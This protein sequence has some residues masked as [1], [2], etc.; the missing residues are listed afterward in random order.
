MLGYDGSNKSILPRRKKAGLT[1]AKL[2]TWAFAYGMLALPIAYFFV[3][4]VYVNFNSIALAFKSPSTGE[5]TFNNFAYVI[6]ELTH[7]GG[8]SL[9][10]VF[11]NTMSFWLL[12]W[13][14]MPINIVVS[15]IL[16]KQIRGYKF[17]QTVFYLPTIISAV[18]WMTAYKNFILPEGPLC[19]VL[20]SLGIFK[21]GAVP[22]L[23]ADSQYALG[24]IMASS[25]WLGI[26]ANMLIY[27]GSLCRI[28]HDIIEAARLDGVGFWREIRYITI[29]MLGPLLS[30]QIL[31]RFTSILS[32]SGNVLLLTG[33]RYNTSTLS[34][35]LYEQVV[36]ND[37]VNIPSAMGLLMTLVTVP[38][39]IMSRVLTKKIENIEY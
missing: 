7:S 19:R 29:P 15:F 36:V 20:V 31:L 18:V 4:Y 33:G 34:Y 32:S 8:T 39:V 22:E 28:P 9:F 6:R 3:F 30:T 13:V 16:Y 2:G 11:K 21:E 5:L 14:M 26:P 27:C 37:Q 35:W 25:V 24:S 38:L 10:T 17:F 1:K 12:G 23:L